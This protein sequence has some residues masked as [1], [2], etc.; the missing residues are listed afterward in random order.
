MQQQPCRVTPSSRLHLLLHR[1]HPS[2]F[3][4]S[5]RRTVLVLALPPILAC[6]LH[7]TFYHYVHSENDKHAMDFS[8][9]VF[10]GR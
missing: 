1:C 10:S 9:P 2:S 8:S 5:L 7:R 3:S 4:L 6:T